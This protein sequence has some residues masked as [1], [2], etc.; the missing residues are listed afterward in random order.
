MQ[1]KYIFADYVKRGYKKYDTYTL[2]QVYGL[3]VSTI[4][5]HELEYWFDEHT[6][7]V[8]MN[9]TI[10]TNIYGKTQNITDM[11]LYISLYDQYIGGRRM[12]F[13]KEQWYSGY[14]HS[15]LGSNRLLGSFCFGKVNKVNEYLFDKN[16]LFHE[17]LDWLLYF[18]PSYLSEESTDTAPHIFLSNVRLPPVG[19]SS[20]CLRQP[21]RYVDYIKL[22]ITNNNGPYISVDLDNS[23]DEKLIDD[24]YYIYK[25]VDGKECTAV[26][27]TYDPTPEMIEY[28]SKRAFR[29][30]GKVIPIKLIESEVK[31][32]NLTKVAS[33]KIKQDIIK[34]YES[35]INNREFI[36]FS[37]REQ[38]SEIINQ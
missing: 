8:K 18:M 1:K 24:G 30:R 17:R 19:R 31:E 25:G 32:S 15:H 38:E 13:T 7:I 14:S 27:L 2:D 5:K 12:S 9:D 29:F 6:L 36:S 22:K 35:I 3:L 26:D 37:K 4:K 11:Y 16:E 34:H 33:P 10:C 23:I 21:F 28:N 20:D